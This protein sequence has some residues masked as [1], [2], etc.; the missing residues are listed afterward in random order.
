MSG[1][2]L[3][4]A[5]EPPS[6]PQHSK[7]LKLAF[8]AAICSMLMDLEAALNTLPLAFKVVIGPQVDPR[9]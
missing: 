4:D 1:G 6:C 8:Q 2:H 7:P 9:P 5:Y 3:F